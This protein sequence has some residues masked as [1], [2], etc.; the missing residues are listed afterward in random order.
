MLPSELKQLEENGKAMAD[1]L[2]RRKG[3][4]DEDSRDIAAL[5]KI[6]LFYHRKIQELARKK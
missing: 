1:I 3:R 5:V 4:D 6:S 2:D